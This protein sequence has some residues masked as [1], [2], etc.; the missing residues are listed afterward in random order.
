M[1]SSSLSSFRAAIVRTVWSS[2]MPLANTLAVLSL[3]VC[4]TGRLVL[5]LRSYYLGQVSLDAS[6]FGVLPW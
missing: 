6:V 4:L 2:R 1:S 5:V 3:L